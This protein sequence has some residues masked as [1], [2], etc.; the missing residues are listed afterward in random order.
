MNA[1][2]WLDGVLTETLWKKKQQLMI[3]AECSNYLRQ[4]L[5][6]A[7]KSCNFMVNISAQHADVT[8]IFTVASNLP[9]LSDLQSYYVVTS[10]LMNMFETLL[11]WPVPAETIA[12]L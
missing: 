6:M 7:I 8:G 1:V 11:L 2:Y 10:N 3:N 5:C 9:T 4:N 12:V